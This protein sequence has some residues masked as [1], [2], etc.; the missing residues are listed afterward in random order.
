MI[1]MFREPQ[2]LTQKGLE[3]PEAILNLALLSA[4]NGMYMLQL[5]Y[6][7]NPVVFF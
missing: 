1:T 3:Q 2:M 5:K 4:R 7:M 6:C